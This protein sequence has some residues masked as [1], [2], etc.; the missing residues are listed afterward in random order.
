MR[1]TAGGTEAAAFRQGGHPEAGPASGLAG[2]ELGFGRAV[3]SDSEDGAGSALRAAVK[4]VERCS[5]V[6]IFSPTKIGVSRSV[7]FEASDSRSVAIRCMKSAG[8]SHS[9]TVMNS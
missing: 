6:P 3:E 1:T 8:S 7:Y 9:K 5:D 2:G 4:A